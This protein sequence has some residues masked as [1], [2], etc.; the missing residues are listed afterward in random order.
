M[1]G[2]I[3]SNLLEWNTGEVEVLSIVA[4]AFSTLGDYKNVVLVNEEIIKLS[5][6]D[7]NAY[8]NRAIAKSEL[9]D[10]QEALNELLALAHGNT[11]FS[12]NAS[13]IYK[14]L[15]R[16][17]KNLISKH[18]SKLNLTNVDPEYLNNVKYKV[19][20]VFEWNLSGADFELQFVNPQKRYFNWEHTNTALATRIEDEIK[21]NYRVE[22]YEFYGDVAGEWV[23]NAKYL[24][25]NKSAEK[26][27]L[28]LKTTIYQDFGYPTQTREDILVHFSQAD[29]KKNLKKLLVD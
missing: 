10:Y 29:E 12:A 19:R 5:P 20:L 21:N 24:G 7:V 16:E 2:K 9:G 26:T 15:K 18:K 23:V 3:I 1:A 17:I 13:G 14:T 6:S 25:E 8:F 11:Y 28:V 4:T 27:P 22:E